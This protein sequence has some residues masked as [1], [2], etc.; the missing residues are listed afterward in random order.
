MEEWWDGSDGRRRL[1]ELELL[2]LL[3]RSRRGEKPTPCNEPVVPSSQVTVKKMRK[4]RRKRRPL[5]RFKISRRT[6]SAGGFTTVSDLG[7]PTLNRGA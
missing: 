1:I 4:L 3:E 5:S 6:G 2:A 7:P